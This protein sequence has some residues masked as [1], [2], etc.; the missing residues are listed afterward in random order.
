MNVFLLRQLLASLLPSVCWLQIKECP[1]MP[2]WEIS[3]DTKIDNARTTRQ[4]KQERMANVESY[5]NNSCHFEEKTFFFSL[6]AGISLRKIKCLAL[7]DPAIDSSHTRC[8]AWRVHNINN[9]GRDIIIKSC[10]SL[11]RCWPKGY[12]SSSVNEWSSLRLRV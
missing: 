4:A 12:E 2:T 3:L 1:F 11:L 6:C 10:V 9:M 8:Y 5:H 7:S